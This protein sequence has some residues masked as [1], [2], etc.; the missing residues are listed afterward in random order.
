MTGLNLETF[1]HLLR[2]DLGAWASLAVVALLLGVMAW[3]SWG[4]RRALRKCLVLSVA[5]HVALVL[6]GSTAPAFFAPGL[7]AAENE[8]VES[9]IRQIKVE[10][11]GEGKQSQGASGA[12]G[13]ARGRLPAWDRPRESL[14]LAEPIMRPDRP[15]PAQSELPTPPPPEPPAP[16]VE[17]PV[18][19]EVR[20]PDRPQPEAL[21]QAVA[22]EKVVEPEQ[23][24]PTDAAELPK[25]AV[26]RASEPEP[27]APAPSDARLRT[28]RTP[29][30]SKPTDARRNSAPATLPAPPDIDVPIVRNSPEPRQSAVPAGAE[31]LGPLPATEPNP[32]PLVAERPSVEAPSA[33]TPSLPIPSDTDLRNRIRAQNARPGTVG[34]P[35]TA[36][37]TNT[38]GSFGGAS[39]FGFPEADV[40]S[41]ARNARANGRSTGGTG[42]GRTGDVGPLALSSTGPAG[43]SSFGS[44]P[45]GSRGSGDVPAPYR[46][47]IDPNRSALAQ[48][49]GASAESELA[50]ERALDWLARHQDADGR[51]N[52]GS[53]RG[54]IDGLE[55]EARSSFTAHCPRGEVCFGECI[56]VE[57]D[58]ALTGLALLAYLG[59]GY[60]HVDGKY[61]ENVAKGLSFLLSLQRPDGDLRGRSLK[62]GMYCHA[63]AALALCEAYALTGDERLR[64]PVERAVDFLVKSQAT[65]G[66]AWRYQPRDTTGDTSILGWVLLVFRT[67]E[68]V[69]VPV[70]AA[71]RAGAR[72]WLQK[73]SAGREGGLA[74]YQP[75]H[76][77][78]PTMTAEA[79]VCRQLLNMDRAGPARD[80]AAAWLLAQS[81]DRGLYNLYYWYYAT[82]AM[83]QQGGADW[84]RWN[85]EVRDQLVRRQR[86]SGHPAGSWDPDDDAD[87]GVKGGRLYSTTLATLTLEVYYRYLRF[88]DEPGPAPRMRQQPERPVDPSLRRAITP[89]RAR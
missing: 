80:E 37:S 81:P 12:G 2:A 48:R 8:R 46:S 55:E 30:E 70:P 33:G 49:A 61:V 31:P 69:G 77:V 34:A 45:L 39:G 78:T 51:W 19:P 58:T 82:L 57:A 23:V 43:P 50:V 84:D 40:R 6:W 36:Q 20:A 14:A 54:K 9:A 27:V 38:D 24:A 88:Y 62:V 26:A 53:A 21:P 65:D 29:S 52:A 4:S 18:A 60:T 42:P 87:F 35:R 22:R 68:L 7:M 25:V 67:A 3:T 17:T 79:W 76:K 74:R 32:D 41:R 13:G 11:V 71:T 15:E 72:A 75:F 44:R 16:V 28:E 63:M 83:Y 5:V 89:G 86:V 47:R 85:L 56:Y 59:A 1:L 10:P 64:G 73:V 66:M